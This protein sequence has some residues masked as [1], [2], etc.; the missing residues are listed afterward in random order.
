M[1]LNNNNYSVKLTKNTGF[2]Y[3][4]YSNDGRSP[5]YDNILPFTLKVTQMIDGFE[6]DI[7][8]I[9]NEYA[10]T[11]E[12]EIKGRKYNG[13]SFVNAS[14]MS[15]DSQ[16]KNIAKYIPNEVY[17]GENLSNAIQVTIKKNSTTIA[18]IHI[19]I[20]FYLDRY[21]ISAI[22]GWDGNSI[23]LN[24]DEGIILTPQ[25]GAGRKDNNRFTGILMGAVKEN[26]SANLEEGL[27]GYH[28][29]VRTLFL[30][31]TTGKAT[32]GRVGQGQ[33]TIDPSDNKAQIVGGNYS[34]STTTGSG[35]LID[36]GTPE[37]KWGNG[38]FAVSAN[39]ILT[40]K[41]ATIDGDIV[42]ENLVLNPATTTV[43]DGNDQIAFNTYIEDNLLDKG[44][45]VYINKISN[46][47]FSDITEGGVKVGVRETF[48]F[49][50]L[51]GTTLSNT[52]DYRD[53]DF[54]L[55]DVG[56]GTGSSNP[57]SEDKNSGK[58]YLKIDSSGAMIADN[59]I[60]R[61]TIVA[62]EGHIG[63]WTVSYQEGLHDGNSVSAANC[64]LGS[65]GK[66]YTIAGASRS[67]IVFKAGS[68]FGV[69][70][71][72]TLY[73]TGADISG[74]VVI[75]DAN[76]T[77]NQGTIGG[78]ISTTTGLK[79]SSSTPTLVL[80]SS[81]VGPYTVNGHEAS[82]WAIYANG[83]FGV[84]TSGNL[85]AS[86]AIISGTLTAGADSKIGPW[87]VSST[88][89]WY[90]NATYGNAD[91]LYFG[92]SGLSLGSAFQVTSGG[93]LTATGVDVT[94][95]INATSGYIGNGANGWTIGS[96]A[97]YNGKTAI[98]NNNQEGVYL[99]VTGIGL[100]ARNDYGTSSS[101]NYHAKFEVTSAGA[102]YASNA[103]V[104]G[105]IAANAGTFGNG[106]N[107]ITIT[108]NGTSDANSAIYSG[109]KTTLNSTGTGFYIGTDGI[110]FGAYNSTTGNPFS[111]TNA[112]AVTAT[113]ITINGG[114][115]NINDKFTVSSA[116]AVTASD[117]SIT[118]GSLNINNGTF[119][120]TSAGALTATSATIS[121]TLTA[122][123]GSS[124]GGWTATANELY[125]GSGTGYVGLN[126]DTTSN[127][128]ETI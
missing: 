126:S 18:K 124:I 33:I 91:G 7:S 6:E 44:K 62:T 72:G 118:G 56:M 16:T 120:V 108:T 96:T 45:I 12:W 92:T 51:D 128:S 53:D 116:G 74:K 88:S 34:Y 94:G 112:G 122:G 70:S 113:N 101:H 80:S 26:A 67:N 52:I 46:R 9:E 14:D 66:T 39:G 106:T 49:Q 10:I 59:A 114:S 103:I 77:F 13:T 19:P 48:Q 81:G 107:K 89:I 24:N 61:G 105:T 40:A 8:T 3:V 93:V 78:W 42:A 32:F 27:L 63:G 87:N 2:R 95:E 99:G 115:L 97:I 109:T 21:G 125:S 22:N 47:S 43:K 28:Q 57:T 71:S 86:N 25:V 90:G 5:K 123:A 83:N 69:N 127:D 15:L 31:A 119:E 102:L 50:S 41:G 85:Y 104:K 73:A 37:I 79:N 60:V 1:Q 20:H 82:N 54:I 68:N 23:V 11:Y 65:V 38:K 4:M 117:I 100:G 98:G 36:L 110:A 64:Y 55:T 30:D 58:T 121:G 84:D 75:T 111:I 35:M 76:S 17:D 29:G